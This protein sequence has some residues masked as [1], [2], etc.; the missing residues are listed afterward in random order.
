MYPIFEIVKYVDLG[1]S[2]FLSTVCVAHLGMPNG[3]VDHSD[4]LVDFRHY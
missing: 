1:E 2:D 4:I 3:K